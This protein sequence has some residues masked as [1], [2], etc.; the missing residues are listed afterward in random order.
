MEIGA[1]VTANSYRN[2][3]LLA[4]IARTVDHISGGRLILAIGSA[5]TNA[6]T[7]SSARWEA[8]STTLAGRCCG[9]KPVAEAQPAPTRR[10]L[11]LIGSSGEQKTLRYAAEHAHIRHSLTD[12]EMLTHK[13]AVL[14]KH[15]AA[16]GRDFTEIEVSTGLRGAVSSTVKARRCWLSAPDSSRPPCPSSYI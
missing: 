9:Q 8:G 10:I 7:T 11:I 4:D 13:L 14:E 16:V 12:A 3:D 5:G 1:L 15:C 2:P 6:T